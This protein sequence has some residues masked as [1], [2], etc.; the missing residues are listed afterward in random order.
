[1]L[2]N[3]V[4]EFFGFRLVDGTCVA[5]I[6][7]RFLAYLLAIQPLAATV[8]RPAAR[9][10]AGTHADFAPPNRQ[11]VGLQ[12]VAGVAALVDAAARAAPHGRDPAR[13]SARKRPY[14]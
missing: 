7:A 13:R 6:V 4:E 10:N 3:G 2:A 14:Q 1:M 12:T 5:D 9:L 11:S 8:D